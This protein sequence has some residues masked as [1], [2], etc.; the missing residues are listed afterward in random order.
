MDVHNGTDFPKG[1]WDSVEAEILAGLKL[2]NKSGLVGKPDTVTNNVTE[3]YMEHEEMALTF[4]WR[5]ALIC[6]FGV[7]IALSIIGNIGVIIVLIFG[8]AKTVL[9]RFLINLALADLTMAIFC[10]PFTFPTI[11][12][13][14]WIF[15]SGMCPTVIFL[16]HVSVF[17]SIYTLTAIGVDRYF[18]VMHPLKIRITKTK[19][20][21]LI[22]L[23]W[24]VSVSLSI[25]QA[26]VARTK[27]FDYKEG[28]IYFC[29][30]WWPSETA[31]TVHEM[32]VIVI[33]YFLPLTALLFTYLRI[34]RRLWGRKLPG[35]ADEQRDKSCANS[36]KKV[37]KMLMV[38]VL[39]FTLCWL[40]LQVFNL[41]IKFSSYQSDH[42]DRQDM[43]RKVN[44]C[45]L[46]L[47]MSNS[48]V[49]PIIY[50][51]L[52]DGFRADMK[53]LFLR[54]VVC[55]RLPKHGS[56]SLVSRKRSLLTATSNSNSNGKSTHY[57]LH[58]SRP[59]NQVDNPGAK[60]IAT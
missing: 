58:L 53:A 59:R 55:R 50:S 30:E 11:I 27:P 40:P 34:G 37:I 21:I 33:S 7:N 23:I 29:S 8:R 31:A 19:G 44:A 22:A 52:N 60:I 45:V 15:S 24:F 28:T 32:F 10:M 18:A 36:K 3:E 56:V 20:K 4:G 26:M 5:T 14:H 39:M 12:Y 16:Q 42:P 41:F 43:I 6:A 25:V 47:A 9:N 48:F 38:V 17:V 51:F 1:Y 57:L 54:C 35:N 49:N 2:L 13:G 46:W